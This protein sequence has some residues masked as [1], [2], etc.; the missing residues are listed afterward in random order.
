M[1]L[2]AV[3][4]HAKGLAVAQKNTAE[5][6][7]DHASVG[8]DFAVVEECAEYDE[9]GEFADAFGGNVLVVEYTEK[10]LA[11]ACAD[12]GGTLSVVR[13]DADVVPEGA[14]GFLRGTC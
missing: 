13:R 4:A 14:A 8:L 2:L 3:H 5:L 10:G 1:K 11:R 7:S 12:W 9:C 6:L